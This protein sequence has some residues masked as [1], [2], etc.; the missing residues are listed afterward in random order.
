MLVSLGCGDDTT[1]GDG[2]IVD[3]GIDTSGCSCAD[4]TTTWDC[5]C[6][7]FDCGKTIDAYA[8]GLGK[9]YVLK[10]EYA[11]CNLVEYWTI[12]GTSQGIDVFDLTTGK[13]VGAH[14]GAAYL[15]GPICPFGGSD[16]VLY[17]LMAGR[18]PETDCVRSQCVEG[19]GSDMCIGADGGTNPKG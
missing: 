16:A 11:G 5:F 10:R 2:T 14:R 3:G 7:V 8:G 15:D 17:S 19:T 18:F 1:A 12:K 4:N 13:L 9:S 6:S